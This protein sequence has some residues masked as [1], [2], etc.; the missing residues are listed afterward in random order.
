[1]KEVDLMNDIVMAIKQNEQEDNKS[2]IR[3]AITEIGNAK[4]RLEFSDG[5]VV[6]VYDFDLNSV[7]AENDIYVSYIH[8]RNPD[9]TAKETIDAIRLL[10][11]AALE[12]AE[13]EPDLVAKL[14][15]QATYLKKKYDDDFKDYQI[16]YTKDANWAAKYKDEIIDESVKKVALMKQEQQRIAR[17]YDTFLEK[18]AEVQKKYAAEKEKLKQSVEK[19]NFI[20]ATNMKDTAALKAEN[21]NLEQATFGIESCEEYLRH[22]EGLKADAQEIERQIKK[23]EK[24]FEEQRKEILD[25]LARKY[26]PIGK[27]GVH[28]IEKSEYFKMLMDNYQ[29]INRQLSCMKNPSL[30]TEQLLDALT[31]GENKEVIADLTRTLVSG[32]KATSVIGALDDE[33]ITSV[34]SELQ[35]LE[36][37]KQK[38]SAALNNKNLYINQVKMQEDNE[39]VNYATNRVMTCEARIAELRQELTRVNEKQEIRA[40]KIELKKITQAIK[41]FEKL[42]EMIKD[43][44]PNLS[45]T[46]KNHITKLT[47]DKTAI[48]GQIEE[49]KKR[50]KPR[51]I[52]EITKEIGRLEVEISENNELIASISNRKEEDYINYEQKTGDTVKLN[53]VKHEI[54][55][56]KRKQGFLEKHDVYALSSKIINS[57]SP[58]KDYKTELEAESYL[59]ID[60]DFVETEIVNYEDAKDSLTEKVKAPKFLKRVGAAIGIMATAGISVISFA[61]AKLIRNTEAK[62]EDYVITDNVEMDTDQVVENPSN[63]M[64]EVTFQTIP[65]NLTT[66]PVE[67]KEELSLENQEDWSKIAER[68]VMQLLYG[69]EETAQ[70]ETK[71]IR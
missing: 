14:E 12:T 10:E 31:K 45:T 53:Q 70:D 6:P 66:L 13:S 68:N 57:Y 59:D 18:K 65:N 23:I 69:N 43:I 50:G 34:G 11:K 41:K 56:L 7:E 44:D 29:L 21:A 33:E 64:E 15:E 24:E 62:K 36:E 9:I 35:K 49:A 32:I 1:M 8:L 3:R 30:I 55:F 17:E 19:L 51:S 61:K 48:Q 67:K 63:K 37:Q 26:G 42:N 38:L 4:G 28:Q 5:T 25:M 20:M 40:K 2:F 39:R 60:E 71:R 46:Y 27:K 16:E 47:E 54:D 58:K 52:S 22:H